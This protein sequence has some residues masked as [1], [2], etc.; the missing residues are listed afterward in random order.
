MLSQNRVHRSCA[1]SGRQEQEDTGKNATSFAEQ[2]VNKAKEWDFSPM[3]SV[4]LTPSEIRSEAIV[5]CGAARQLSPEIFERS[6]PK[7]FNSFQLFLWEFW[8]TGLSA[9]GISLC[10]CIGCSTIFPFFFSHIFFLLYIL[11]FV[12][13]ICIYFPTVIIFRG[14]VSVCFLRGF[15]FLSVAIPLLP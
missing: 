14:I 3:F 15:P 10:Y 13:P 11:F 6:H 9:L 12:H 1:V 2:W 5:C 7:F 8:R 4:D